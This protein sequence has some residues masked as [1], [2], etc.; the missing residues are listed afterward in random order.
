MKNFIRQFAL[1]V[2]IAAGFVSTHAA[3]SELSD[4]FASVSYSN[5]VDGFNTEVRTGMSFG[6]GAIRFGVRAQYLPKN[7]VTFTPPSIAVSC[8]GISW[9]FGGFSFVNG[10]E[11]IQAI[12]AALPAAAMYV[13]GIVVSG[14][15]EQCWTG[16]QHVF[17]A[18][19]K[20]TN[21][22]RNSCALGAALAESSGLASAARS[23]REDLCTL[24]KAAVGSSTDQMASSSSCKQA[25]VTNT[26][27]KDVLDSITGSSSGA[28]TM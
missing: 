19:N 2:L 4:A 28:P 14:L 7:T 25:E 3:A 24:G 18:V 15:C 27:F 11:I 9:H 23:V 21:A 10:D 12:E 17:D 6:S 8:N 1:A 20:V 22:L 5:G 16:L 26:Y 13:L